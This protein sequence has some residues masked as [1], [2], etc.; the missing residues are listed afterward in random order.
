MNRYKENELP[1]TFFTW[2]CN[3]PVY[4]MQHLSP[5]SK[6]RSSGIAA[7]ADRRSVSLPENDRVSV[8]RLIL[9]DRGSLCCL[10][11]VSRS[12]TTGSG[13]YGT[14][15]G[16]NRQVRPFRTTTTN[17]VRCPLH[18]RFRFRETRHEPDARLDLRSSWNW[19][20]GAGFWCWSSVSKLKVAK[21]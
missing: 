15:T 1:G 6:A 7:A 2:I 21:G 18:G 13:L 20:P 14:R 9:I 4:W 12:F 3:F 17:R 16:S 10:G 5:A 11:C 8:C 19:R